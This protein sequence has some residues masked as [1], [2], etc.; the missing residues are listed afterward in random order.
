MVLLLTIGNPNNALALAEL[1]SSLLSGMIKACFLAAKKPGIVT[2][3][4]GQTLTQ[5]RQNG[6][7]PELIWDRLFNLSLSLSRGR[8]V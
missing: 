4:M 2:T 8:A 5:R 1:A 3:I 6:V 7:V